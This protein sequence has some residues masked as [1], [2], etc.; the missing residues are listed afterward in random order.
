MN[1]KKAACCVLVIIS[2]TVMVHTGQLLAEQLEPYNEIVILID[3]SGS[4]KSR[5]PEAM[6]KSESLLD[7]M[8]KQKLHRWD[9]A[10]DRITI[11]R[12]D[13]L[14]DVLWQGS[15][16]ELKE[17]KPDFWSARFKART[18][19][20][21]CTDVSAGF[22]L[23]VS[24]LSGD[25]RYIYKY[26]FVFSDLIDEPPSNSVYQPSAKSLLPL[27]DFPWAELKDVSVSAFWVPPD[28]KLAWRREVEKHGLK[29]FSL[30][31]TSESG[32]VSIDAP[33]KPEVE[34]TEE[35]IKAGQQR[36][37]GYAAKLLKGIAIALFSI[38]GIIALIFLFRSAGLRRLNIRRFIGFLRSPT[39]NNQGTAGKTQKNRH[40]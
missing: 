27:G 31:T 40:Q 16:R 26:L 25:P 32:E 2:V 4:Y 12:L 23:A 34:L 33:Q 8:S 21:A 30:Y 10:V 13:A 37:M 14:P 24:Y 3:S 35:E 6:K 19:Y 28:Q 36:Y 38:F 22:S 17:K 7:S 1:I 29:N 11:I 18:D 20:E 9:E 5:Q 39:A 15:L